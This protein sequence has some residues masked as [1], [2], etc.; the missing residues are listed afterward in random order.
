MDIES[1]V[2][3]NITMSTFPMFYDTVSGFIAL[4]LLLWINIEKLCFEPLLPD[5]KFIKLRRGRN[6]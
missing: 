2:A 4:D 6:I 1:T 5:L 3:H